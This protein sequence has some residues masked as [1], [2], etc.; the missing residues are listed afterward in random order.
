MI[1]AGALVALL[2]L[3]A[4]ALPFLLD[5]E[6]YRP[7]I[8]QAIAGATGRAVT[9]GPMRLTLFPA[10]ELT[11]AGFSIG[12]DPR[13]G[14]EP[15]LR[16]KRRL[17]VEA[18]IIDGPAVRLVRD[19]KGEWNYASLVRPKDGEKAPAGSGAVGRGG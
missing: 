14:T 1:V 7:S 18:L 10:A 3:V 4:A 15:F 12:E 16:A 13:F 11:A 9:I 8:E 2:I 19:A 17:V 6:R 5:V